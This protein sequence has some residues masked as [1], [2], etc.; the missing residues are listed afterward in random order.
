MY[1][2]PYS[3]P[4]HSRLARALILILLASRNEFDIDQLNGIIVSK[5]IPDALLRSHYRYGCPV[6]SVSVRL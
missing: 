4:S 2:L 1:V 6:R 5:A 3:P